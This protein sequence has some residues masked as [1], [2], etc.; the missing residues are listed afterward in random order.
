MGVE[1]LQHTNDLSFGSKLASMK[2]FFLLLILCVFSTNAVGEGLDADGVAPVR[3]VAGG[4]AAQ[5]LLNRSNNVFAPLAGGLFGFDGAILQERAQARAASALGLMELADIHFAQM[6]SFALR[7]QDMSSAMDAL[8]E[9]AR[10]AFTRGDYDACA[11]FIEEELVIARKVGDSIREV[12][13]LNG[14]GTVARRMDRLDEAL[15]YF[16]QALSISERD[17]DDSSAAQSLLNLSVVYKSQGDYY[18]ALDV[19]LRALEIRSRLGDE[20]G[21]D[22]TYHYLGLMYKHLEDFAQARHFLELA[23]KRAEASQNTIAM[24]PIL[25]S[26]ASLANDTGRPQEG[27]DYA[28]RARVIN[29]RFKSKS[30]HSFDALEMGRAE[31]ALGHA[32]KARAELQTSLALST[33]LSQ[34]RTGADA[35]FYLAQLDE[36]EGQLEAALTQFKRAM[37]IFRDANDR[38]RLLDCF[39][40]L[41][42]I[43]PKMGRVA[44]ALDFSQQRYALREELLGVQSGRRMNDLRVRYERMQADRQ[45]ELL[46]RENELTALGIKNQRLQRI[47]A[48]SVAAALFALLALTA[49]RFRESKR[50]NAEL[51]AKHE[52]VLSQTQ[53]LEIAH[54]RLE[55]QAR[56]LYRASITDPLTGCYNRGF[57]IRHLDQMLTSA[58]LA[59]QPV[60]LLLLDLDLFKR[61]NDEYGHLMGDRVIVAAV[62]AIS[63][64][65]R[66][67]DILAR[68]GGEEFIVALPNCEPAVAQLIAERLRDAVA[69]IS[70]DAAGPLPT[71]TLSVGLSCLAAGQNVAV[72]AFIAAA[73]AAMYAAKGNGRNRVEREDPLSTATPMIRTTGVTGVQA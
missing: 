6:Y 11:R 52:T 56:E 33:E 46:K 3:P 18:R 8:G 43:L 45:I 58:A 49:W 64:Q 48:I 26:L 60:A 15:K 66:P 29:Q 30:G 7:A 25:G 24:A 21:L 4:D 55:D 17:K 57:V 51:R 59:R 13:A 22:R 10:N 72:K 47:L 50:L 40:A 53:S 70:Q 69:Q 27:L 1:D 42:R 16:E 31:L 54:A 38:P 61:I 62:H 28:A 19:Q 34:P 20:S 23:I 44:E 39:L 37:G 73:D 63:T 67:D 68:Y 35:L 36:R 2:R 71:L 12:V 9:Q 5:Q 65:L 32:Q 14:L 41:E